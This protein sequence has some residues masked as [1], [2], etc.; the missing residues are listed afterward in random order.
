MTVAYCEAGDCLE[1][2]VSTR[3]RFC[4]SACRQRHWRQSR[5]SEA[6]GQIEY[7]CCQHCLTW[8]SWVRSREGQQ[9]LYC[10]TACS[11]AA[12]RVRVAEAK[13]REEERKERAREQRARRRQEK[14]DWEEWERR[15]R[16]EYVYGGSRARDSSS[17]AGQDTGSSTRGSTH[18]DARTLI[19]DLAGLADDGATTLTKAYRRAAMRLHPDVG[20]DVEEFKRLEQAASVLKRAGLF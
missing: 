5:L 2:V 3:A 4:S 1:F 14:R 10:S 17:S 15:F 11:Q 13:R 9:R 16:E 7:I 12:Y 6:A 20:G 19:F 18:G 8:F